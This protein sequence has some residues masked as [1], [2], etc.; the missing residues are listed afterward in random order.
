MRPYA[1]RT[2][3][4]APIYDVVL[5]PPDRVPRIFWPLIP[6][7]AWE[8]GDGGLDVFIKGYRGG[9]EW[10]LWVDV[11]VEVL[12]KGLS[13]IPVGGGGGGACTGLAV[14]LL[15]L[16]VVAL[17]THAALRPDRKN[18]V[19]M[20]CVLASFA[21]GFMVVA[22]GLAGRGDG[23]MVAVGLVLA[24]I[25]QVVSFV[26]KFGAMAMKKYLK[27]KEGKSEGVHGPLSGQPPAEDSTP[28]SP[29][30]PTPFESPPPE[31]E[32]VTIPPKKITVP[33][34]KVPKKINP[35]E[36]P[37]LE[38]RPKEAEQPLPKPPAPPKPKPKP[39]AVFDDS[40]L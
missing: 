5:P 27:K 10:V 29:P 35:L 12:W 31:E 3:H 1:A 33:P 6:H 15:V 14:V 24:S 4:I 40:D 23:T 17:V 16:D 7:G 18:A 37:M 26:V 9:R 39:K 28:F 34:K 30:V 11:G 36:D 38:P 22:A 20:D 21:R 2:D 25:S 8:V 13:A 32:L 19:I